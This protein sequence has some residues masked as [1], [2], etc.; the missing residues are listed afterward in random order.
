MKQLR[1]TSL[2]RVFI[3]KQKLKIRLFKSVFWGSIALF[4]AIVFWLDLV[5]NPLNEYRLITK[6]ITTDGQ[7]TKAEEEFNE[8]VVNTYYEYS[9][10]LPDGRVITSHGDPSGSLPDELK[11]SLNPAATK[12]VYLGD[13]PEINEIKNTLPDGLTEFFLRKILVGAFLLFGFSSVGFIVIRR[14]I[15]SYLKDIRTIKPTEP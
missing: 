8:N 3:E 15:L 2:I 9:F 1:F 13:N 12:V 11:D 7:I 4:V 5:G 10:V 14:G 6:G